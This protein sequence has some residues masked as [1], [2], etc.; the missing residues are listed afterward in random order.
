MEIE[1]ASRDQEGPALPF[2]QAVLLWRL[3]RGLTQAQLAQRAGL[4]RPNLS[5]IEQGRRDVSLRTLWALAAALGV[6]AGTLADGVAPSAVSGRVR[7]LSRVAIERVAD[8]VAF[9]RR[10]SD[11]GERVVAGKLR[12]LL[13]HRMDA[14]HGRRRRT[15]G[16]P[17]TAATAWTTLN[18][19]CGREV[20]QTLADRVAE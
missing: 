5:A 13:A 14:I 4:P 10:L 2:G 16:G 17:R 20:I 8:A 18:S 7:A 11:P 19:L 3:K 15:R 1:G 6:R 9:G 12:V